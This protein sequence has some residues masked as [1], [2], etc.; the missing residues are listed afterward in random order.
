M[1]G[2]N[3]RDWADVEDFIDD[4]EN[5]LAAVKGGGGFR[6]IFF[7]I[8]YRLTSSLFQRPIS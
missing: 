1:F 7:K 4:L 6:C 2:L 3:L 8:V 5:D